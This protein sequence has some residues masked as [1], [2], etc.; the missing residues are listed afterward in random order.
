MSQIHAHCVTGPRGSFGAEAEEEE[1][2]LIE[3]E[4][5]TQIVPH[6]ST[7]ARE[8]RPLLPI[9]RLLHHAQIMWLLLMMKSVR[10]IW[11][12]TIIKPILVFNRRNGLAGTVG[13]KEARRSG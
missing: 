12:T 10:P 5:D 2:I 1:T 8:L 6:P 9:M 3:S 7:S 4:L 11:A 13:L